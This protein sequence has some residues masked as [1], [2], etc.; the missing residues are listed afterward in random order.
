MPVPRR[1]ATT[2]P[3]LTSPPSPQLP[4][5]AATDRVHWF[6]LP[7]RQAGVREAR[8]V[9]GEKLRRWRLPEEVCQDAVLILSELVTNAIRHTS[10]SRIH[11]RVGLT[12]DGSVHLEVH[13]QAITP[14]SLPPRNPGPD[15]ECGRGLLLV[16]HI[17]ERWGAERSSF[18]GGNAV[19]AALARPSARA[20]ATDTGP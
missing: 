5:G 9:M 20:A 15:D 12:A 14:R 2:V 3:S 11:C 17:A 7:A 1:K 13:D 18:T 16:Q 19:W 10:S 4:G 6:E 8:C